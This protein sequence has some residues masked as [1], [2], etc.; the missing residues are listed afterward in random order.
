M[1][2]LSLGFLCWLLLTAAVPPGK[3]KRWGCCSLLF[4]RYAGSRA[5]CRVV[6]S[7]CRGLAK[8]MPVANRTSGT[9]RSTRQR[10]ENPARGLCQ[11]VSCSL[12]L[13]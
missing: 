13:A 10:P 9:D 4:G 8:L 12:E 7:G 2:S 3:A 1:R 11:L 5:V 6:Y